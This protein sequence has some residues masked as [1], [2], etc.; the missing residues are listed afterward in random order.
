MTNPSHAQIRA[1]RTSLGLT[2]SEFAQYLYCSFRA[3]QQWEGGQRTMPASTW[4]LLQI[5]VTHP[6]ITCSL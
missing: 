5:K 4:V 2:Q 6:E 3:V 1:L